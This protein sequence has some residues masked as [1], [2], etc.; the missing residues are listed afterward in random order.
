[1][2]AKDKAKKSAKW[3]S[4]DVVQAV[5]IADS[6]NFRFQP[7]TAERPRALLP[8]VNRYLI[9]YTVE[10]LAFSGVQEIFVYCCA[11]SDQI[12]E[13]IEKCKWN[14][15]SSPVKLHTIVSEDCPSVGDA[16][17]DIDAQALIRSDFVLVSGD[18]VSN[19]ELSEVIAKHKKLR[20][21]DKMTVMTNVYKRAYPGH[22]TRSAED[23]ILVVTESSTGRV[24]FCEKPSGKKGRID[25]PV[26]IFEENDQVEI[27][28]DIL[29]CHIS[30]CSPAVPQLFS[31]NFD[32]QSRY[33]FVR[34]IIV[35]EEVLGN[36]IYG[37][38]I[39]DQ[40]AARVGNLTTYEAV[41]KDVIHRWV[42]PLVPDNSALEEGYS[43]G[44]RNI[45]LADDISLAF[46][47][48]LEEDVVVGSGTC[49]GAQTF[50]THSSIGRNAKIGK[51]VRI[52]G[53]YIWNNV[54]IEDNCVLKRSV[55]ASN[56]HIKSNV[57][58]EAGCMISFNVVVGEGFTV[59]TGTRLTTCQNV[60]VTCKD[61]WGEDE[62]N[63]PTPA[64]PICVEC[65]EGDVGVGGRGFKW[66][67]PTPD[68]DDEDV[69]VEK[70]QLHSQSSSGGEL[71]DDEE[72]QEEEEEEPTITAATGA[73]RMGS[74]EKDESVLFY[75][76]ILDNIRSGLADKVTNE[77]TILMINASKHAYN[78]PI[79]E[80]P[81]S[82]IKAVMEGTTPSKSESVEYVLKAVRYFQSL[83]S[84]Y[85]KDRSVQISV[86][87]TLAELIT[88]KDKAFASVFAKTILELYNLDILEEASIVNWYDHASKQS[89]PDYAELLKQVKPVI[90]WLETAEEESEESD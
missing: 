41:S 52:E 38:F 74:V 81:I 76:E 44:R 86:I 36:T 75:Q 35:N 26:N 27:N 54:T 80:V 10:F 51:G 21:V 20:E 77:N 87:S 13:H 12:K 78:I 67:P 14:K 58:V 25:I 16:L 85:I 82:I 66:V 55:I 29:D 17:R 57:S 53:C 47:C 34:G 88:A 6:F 4:E 56:V 8:L 32:Y 23:N 31:D 69:F 65:V 70:W 18:L 84:H 73:G 22:R 39:S 40:Y 64:S 46:D 30:V 43:Y 37:H 5:V 63:S 11:H 62:E 24:L 68:S 42:F 59:S 48:I 50:I 28:Y 72:V 90:D 19:M 2:S 61:E 89:N 49:V 9:D 45:Y 79:N 7:I 71:L 3:S 83:L 60:N 15:P 33:H 1:M